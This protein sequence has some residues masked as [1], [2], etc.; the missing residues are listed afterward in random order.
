MPFLEGV[1]VIICTRWLSICG[2]F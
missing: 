1:H 2:A